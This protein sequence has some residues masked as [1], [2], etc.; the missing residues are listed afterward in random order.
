MIAYI[1]NVLRFMRDC[2]SD[3]AKYGTTAYK[4]IIKNINTQHAPFPCLHCAG[5]DRKYTS[6]TGM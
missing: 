1:N 4:K 2:Y 6:A 3:A 5:A